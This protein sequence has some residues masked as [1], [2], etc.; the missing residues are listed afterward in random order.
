MAY[1]V[2]MFCLFERAFDLLTNIEL[3]LKVLLLCIIR[4]VAAVYTEP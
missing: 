4:T 1:D 3:V 2:P